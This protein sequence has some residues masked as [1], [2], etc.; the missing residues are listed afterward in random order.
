MKKHEW[1]HKKYLVCP[2][3]VRSKDGDLHFVSASQLINLY[4]VERDECVILDTPQSVFGLVWKDYIVLE[5]RGDGNYE[6]PKK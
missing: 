6:L 4:K 3:K 5:P 2:G 1:Y